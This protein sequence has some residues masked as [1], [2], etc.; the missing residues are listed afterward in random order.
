[1]SGMTHH[2][3]LHPGRNTYLTSNFILSV[4]FMTGVETSVVPT[5]VWDPLSHRPPSQG[6]ESHTFLVETQ[7]DLSTWSRAVVPIQ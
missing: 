7:R 3:D 6:V 4:L 5:R 1:M 2:T